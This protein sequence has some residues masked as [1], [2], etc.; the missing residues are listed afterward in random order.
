MQLERFVEVLIGTGHLEKGW[1]RAEGRTG[2]HKGK[3]KE[4]F[5]PIRAMTRWTEWPVG[6]NAT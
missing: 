4:H 1:Q 3:L 5:P 2:T 6:P